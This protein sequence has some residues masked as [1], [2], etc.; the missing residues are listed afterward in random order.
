VVIDGS[1]LPGEI[2]PQDIA[3]DNADR[4]EQP[5]ALLHFL[6]QFA[7]AGC[8]VVLA[9]RS[10]PARWNTGLPDLDSRLRALIAVEIGPP[11]D[12][13]LQA[14]LAQLLAE[15]QLLV[16]QPLQDWLRIRL[17]RT[18]HAMREAAAALDTVSLEAGRGVSRGLI[19]KVLAQFGNGD[20]LQTS[21]PVTSPDDAILI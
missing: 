2:S 20:L 16:P 14:L 18:A 3:L 5:R 1:E 7:E 10:P 9:G 21:A 8:A 19:A 17:P 15:R 12:S 6:N 13:L 4:V 11:E